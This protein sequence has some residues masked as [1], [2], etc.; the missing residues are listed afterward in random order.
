MADFDPHLTPLLRA[1][2]NA[3]LDPL[4]RLLRKRMMGHLRR[5]DEVA[6]MFPDH[7]RYVDDIVADLRQL[8]GHALLD[9]VVGEG[10]Q[11]SYLKIVRG[12]ARD[13][14]KAK[15]NSDDVAELELLIIKHMLDTRFEA[16]EPSHQAA[17]LEAFWR[18]HYF[19]E[20]LSK[21]PRLAWLMSRR[22]VDS[23]RPD[24]GKLKQAAK[25]AVTGKVKGMA[26]RYGLR[27][28]ARGA[29][30]PLGVA[31][32]AWDWLGP[33]DRMI[34]PAVCY[35]GWLRERHAHAALNQS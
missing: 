10:G 16:L 22:G 2:D 28:V 30:A 27:L 29:A 19:R 6:R 25:D 24:L 13:I 20:G 7:R 35:V 9:R 26:F 32:T 18:G 33:D 1:Q 15:A 5:D 23:Q 11:R 34:I 17:L 31:M 4:V 21:H 8:G 3:A 14:D 12:L